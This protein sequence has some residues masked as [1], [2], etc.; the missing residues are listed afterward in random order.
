MDTIFT[1]PSGVHLPSLPD[2]ADLTGVT[3]QLSGAA[4]L[5]SALA[6]VFYKWYRLS[7]IPGPFWTPYSFFRLLSRGRVYEDFPA[8][9]EKYGS[10]SPLPPSKILCEEV[11]DGKSLM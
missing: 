10:Q 6:Y 1:I 11:E 5:L 4:L 8:L 7:H 2:P 9:N 3:L